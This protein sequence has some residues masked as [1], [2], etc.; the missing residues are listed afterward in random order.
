MTQEEEELLLE[1]V[2]T[3]LKTKDVGK[4]VANKG[5]NSQ[6]PTWASKHK[7]GLRALGINT[8]NDLRFITT[9]MLVSLEP[10]MSKDDIVK[11]FK[12]KAEQGGL[13][14]Q[15]EEALL[16]QRFVK[17]LK[18]NDV[19]K[20]VANQR[21]NSHLPGWLSKHKKGLRAL[22]IHTRNDLRFITTE[23]LERLEPAMS[24]DDIEK[25]FKE[26]AEQG[27]IMAQDEEELLPKS[28]VKE[29]NKKGGWISSAYRSQKSGGGRD[30][31]L[32]E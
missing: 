28:F 10:A 3:S 26:K 15:E 21:R 8:R 7:E 4:R 6:L 25:A 2:V 30:K 18:T 11:Y 13:M 14:A 27:G 19:W 23:M 22:G 20:R 17:S 24:K 5:L 32:Q 16:L 1:H 12:E 31:S 29:L 9:E